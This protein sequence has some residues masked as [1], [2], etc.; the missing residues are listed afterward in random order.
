MWF[1]ACRQQD[2]LCT[3][4]ANCCWFRA[5]VGSVSLLVVFPKYEHLSPLS[6]AESLHMY[7]RSGAA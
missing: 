1:L 4:H 6:N 7:R 2:R 3:V 5:L